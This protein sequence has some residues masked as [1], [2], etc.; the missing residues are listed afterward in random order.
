[1]HLFMHKTQQIDSSTMIRRKKEKEENSPN[2]IEEENK[3]T[4]S[5]GN[6]LNNN[7]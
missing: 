7:K 1:M 5:T 6:E 3:L 2:T 4:M